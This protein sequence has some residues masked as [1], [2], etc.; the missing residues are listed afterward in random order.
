MFESGNV[1]FNGTFEN[2]LLNGRGTLYFDDAPNSVKMNGI[3]VNGSFD[4]GI[5]FNKT[6]SVLTTILK[7]KIVNTTNN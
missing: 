2:D 1:A 4:T 3:F 5:V 7:G 6:G